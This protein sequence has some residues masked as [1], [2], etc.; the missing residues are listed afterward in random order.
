MSIEKLQLCPFPNFRNHDAA[1]KIYTTVSS[2][3]LRNLLK[4]QLSF[5]YTIVIKVFQVYRIG[6]IVKVDESLAVSPAL[7]DDATRL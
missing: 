7:Y 3:L 6:I 5:K 2:T 4:G 1:A